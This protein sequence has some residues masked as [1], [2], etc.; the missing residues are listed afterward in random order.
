M[1]TNQV[2]TERQSKVINVLRGTMD[3]MVRPI[4]LSFCKDHMQKLGIADTMQIAKAY[5]RLKF[6]RYDEYR[7]AQYRDNSGADRTGSGHPGV[8]CDGR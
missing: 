3:K 8:Y 5:N 4:A 7:K 1:W 2:F 6:G